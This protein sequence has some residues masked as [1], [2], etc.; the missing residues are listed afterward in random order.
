[1]VVSTS[2]RVINFFNR[3]FGRGGGSGRSIYSFGRLNSKNVNV[4][5]AENI[6]SVYKSYPLPFVIINDITDGVKNTPIWIAKNDIEIESASARRF[7]RLI[8]EPNRRK[9]ANLFLGKIAFELT[10]FG[11]CFVQK[12]DYGFGEPEYYVIENTTIKSVKYNDWGEVERLVCILGESEVTHRENVFELIY[13][14]ADHSTSDTKSL[15]GEYICPIVA[16][17][18]EIETYAN[19]IDALNNSYGDGGARKIISFKN[20]DG[21]LSY[22]SDILE[23]EKSDIKRQLK[24]EYGR[25]TGDNKY[26]LTKGEAS[27]HDLSLPTNQLD[28]PNTKQSLETTICNAFK[29]PPQLLGIKSGAYKSNTEAEK[30]F[31]TRCVSPL[32][33]YIFEELDKIFETG[34]MKQGIRIELDYTRYDFFQE[35][36]QK[37]GAAIQ[38]FAQGIGTLLDRK[39]ITTE[40]AKT[41]LN[42]IL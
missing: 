27:T 34:L 11:R 30:A 25:N 31:Y 2:G 26:I 40:Q 19:L 38:T 1:M 15:S 23:H 8:H 18:E 21:S 22:Y 9:N 4:V 35:G 42:S 41:E 37:K 13:Y 6:F 20:A 28:A 17:R 16:Q 3:L 24:E 36:K 7:M 12:K 32:A 14:N 33:N 39:L 10:T 29:Y 5:T